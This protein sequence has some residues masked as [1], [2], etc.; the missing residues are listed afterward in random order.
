MSK[1]K[2]LGQPV[3]LHLPKKY[4]GLWVAVK[5]TKVVGAGPT[6][7]KALA[8]ASKKG[9][10]SPKLVRVPRQDEHYLY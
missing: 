9:E 1:C 8:D 7:D 5:G 6:I 10:T 2:V 4:A 3:S